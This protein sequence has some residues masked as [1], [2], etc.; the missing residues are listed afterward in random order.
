LDLINIET[1][2]FESPDPNLS[3]FCLWDWMNR[4][5]YKT[6]VDTR[7]EMFARILNAAARIK[8]REDQLR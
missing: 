2:L 5:I 1:E 8:K 6:R 7:D 3:D 4:E